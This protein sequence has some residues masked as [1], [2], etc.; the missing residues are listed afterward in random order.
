[1]SP[2]VRV[3]LRK[4]EGWG[5]VHWHIMAETEEVAKKECEELI[6]KFRPSITPH[7]EWRQFKKRGK[8]L[9]VCSYAYVYKRGVG[10]REID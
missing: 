1:M 4:V 5:E 8:N 9:Y 7:D 3:Q 2:A 10:R 6:Q